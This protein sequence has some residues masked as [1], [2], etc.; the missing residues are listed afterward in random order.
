MNIK[1]NTN[2]NREGIPICIPICKKDIYHGVRMKNDGV[3]NIMRGNISNLSA[4]FN[5]SNAGEMKL[6]GYLSSDDYHAEYS[7]MIKNLPLHNIYTSHYLLSVESYLRGLVPLDN[8]KEILSIARYFPGNITSFL[9][10]ECRLGTS[11][12]RVDWAFAISSVERDRFVFANLLNNGYMPDQFMQQDAWRRINDFV[13]AWIN[14][15]SFLRH[16]INCFWLEFDMPECLPDVPVPSIFFGPGKPA[17]GRASDLSN[18]EWIINTA[19]PI[20]KGRRLKKTVEYKIRECLEALP[21][22]ASLFQVGMMLSR[23]NDVIRLCVNH[24]N[25]EQ[26]I[27]YL[28]TIGWRDETGEF[29]RLMK[30]LEDKA[31]R[32][33]LGF[34]VTEEGIGSRIGVELSFSSDDFPYAT[35]WKR[36]LDYLVDKGWCLPEKREALLNYQDSEV[37]SGGVMKPLTSASRC[38]DDLINSKIVR[39][40]NHV[41][42]VYEPGERVE[43]KAYPAVRLFNEVKE[44]DKNI[45]K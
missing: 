7:R 33:V 29:I 39:Y 22:N 19:L 3:F 9:G 34:D 30:E 6:E 21:E 8:L 40:I 36:L 25:P 11:D 31:D 45:M 12:S 10:F 43:A 42:I 20:L 1:K 13:N 44:E 15:D 14:P 28:N 35:R 5:V 41:K 38:L 23:S 16:N 24:M 37:F 2:N 17:N 32:F 27:S 26:I 18:Y 4:S